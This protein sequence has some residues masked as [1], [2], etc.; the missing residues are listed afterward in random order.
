MKTPISAVVER[1]ENG[2]WVVRHGPGVTD[3]EHLRP[4]QFRFSAT[5]PQYAPPDLCAPFDARPDTLRCD[6]R[7]IWPGQKIELHYIADRNSG[8]LYAFP[9]PAEGAMP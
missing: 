3:I 4:W 6:G 5:N 1:Y 9:A 7:A 8:L 2:F